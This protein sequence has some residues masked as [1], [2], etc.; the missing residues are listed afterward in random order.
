MPIISQADATTEVGYPGSKSSQVGL[1]IRFS[2]PKEAVSA[3]RL[4]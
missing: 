4:E 3:S 2:A 1:H